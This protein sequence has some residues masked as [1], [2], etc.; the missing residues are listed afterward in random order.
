[1]AQTRRFDEVNGSC[2]PIE[3]PRREIVNTLDRVV[4]GGFKFKNVKPGND[5]CSGNVHKRRGSI[6]ST[7]GGN[8]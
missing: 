7:E 6:Q 2:R 5:L 4:A 3:P 1:M 8:R